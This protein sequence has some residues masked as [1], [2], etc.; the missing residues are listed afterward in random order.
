[1][2]FYAPLV[3]QMGERVFACDACGTEKHAPFWCHEKKPPC[4]WVAYW[5]SEAAPVKHACAKCWR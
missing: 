2:T 4:T 3:P 1:M 5:K